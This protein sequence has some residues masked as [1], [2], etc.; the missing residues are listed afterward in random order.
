MI[1]PLLHSPFKHGFGPLQKDDLQGAVGGS[2]QSFPI[3]PFQ[4]GARHH[5]TCAGN[6]PQRGTD[7]FQ[8][9]PA[10]GVVKSN[11]FRHLL[12]IRPRM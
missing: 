9:W 5:D 4:G 3:G 6:R 12:D 8:P 1:R 11:P 7:L 10:V 2:P